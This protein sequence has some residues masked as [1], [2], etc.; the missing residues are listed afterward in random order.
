MWRTSELVV[1]VIILAAIQLLHF[2]PMRVDLVIEGSLA[3]PMSAEASVPHRMQIGRQ[4]I[5][6]TIS[7]QCRPED[8]PT[9]GESSNAGCEEFMSE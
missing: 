8:D 3:L 5:G 7:A 6:L 2:T 9:T 1:L 4:M